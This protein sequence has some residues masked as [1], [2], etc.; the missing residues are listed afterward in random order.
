MEYLKLPDILCL[1]HLRWDFVFQRPQQLLTRAARD[2]R[3]FFYEERLYSD[4]IEPRLHVGERAG[5]VR[6]AMPLLPRELREKDATQAAERKLCDDLL[7]RFNV[8]NYI[9]W[10]YTPMAVDYTEHLRPMLTVY[11]C[12]DE[13][14]GFEQAPPDLSAKEA[15]LFQ[16]ADLVF[17]G[18]RSLYEAKRHLHPHVSLFPSSVDTAH[19]SQA[20]S[21]RYYGVIDE[22][23]DLQLLDGIAAATPQWHYV[24][25]GPIAKIRSDRLPQRSNLHFLGAKS[26]AELPAYI[27][28]WHVALLPFARNKATRFISPTKVPEYLAAGKPIVSTPIEDVV[29][30][31]GEGEMVY[32]AGTVSDFIA[33]AHRAMNRDGTV[34]WLRRVDEHLA[35]SSW[36]STWQRMDQLIDSALG[37]V[38]KVS[39]RA[40]KAMQTPCCE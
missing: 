12:M 7:A 31:Y 5:S 15:R 25:V 20:R 11:D 28:G 8:R 3:V 24:L 35:K 1:S 26:Y 10:F 14:S 30:E 13:L 4:E 23:M 32:I 36:D 39:F 33:A 40:I 9:L 18:G 16:R 34:E 6:V 29:C 22:R 21:L 19:F 38:S 37:H 17:T 27:A 2:R